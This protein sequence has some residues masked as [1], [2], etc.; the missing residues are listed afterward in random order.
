MCQFLGAIIVI[1]TV[2]HFYKD[3]SM[4]LSDWL[5]SGVTLW[6]GASLFLT[7][8]LIIAQFSDSQKASSVANLLNMAMAIVG[9]LWFP[10]NTFPDWLQTISKKMPTYH[11]K[12]MSLDLGKDKGI[13][14]ESLG[15]L[16]V[17]SI[18]FLSIALLINKKKDVS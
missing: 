10:I 12:Q 5:L 3:V 16:L 11:L 6:V 9:G 8:G 14:Y 17:Y 13:N 7:L 4:N 1:F 15:F 18:I 2:A